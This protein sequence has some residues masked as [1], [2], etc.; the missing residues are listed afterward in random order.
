MNRLAASVLALFA[1]VIPAWIY[2]QSD[3][4][5]QLYCILANVSGS[6]CT[7]LLETNHVEPPPGVVTTPAPTITSPAP[8]SEGLFT[9]AAY[10]QFPSSPASVPSA[11]D[12]SS[13]GGSGGS[14]GGGGGAGQILGQIAQTVGGA[15]V[16][17]FAGQA[18]APVT[19]AIGSA[20]QPI[21]DGISSLFSG[22]GEAASAA[23]NV[24]TNGA[25]NA[26]NVAGLAANAQC[27][28]VIPGPCP[29]GTLMSPEAHGCVPAANKYLC[30]CLATI[31]GVGII[32]G[33]CMAPNFC[34]GNPVASTIA[35]VALS[36][37][38]SSVIGAVA[39]SG[40]GGANGASNPSDAS[41]PVVQAFGGPPVGEGANQLLNGTSYSSPSYASYQ[42]TGNVHSLLF[43][44]GDPNAAS[45]P[46]ATVQTASNDAVD[47][48]LRS[49]TI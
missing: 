25:S 6:A 37:A 35:S 5:S 28:P 48:L 33:Q 15:V 41:N 20:F 13:G 11:S 38:L 2:A 34:L 18:L 9:P 30:P 1:I 27:N 26:G 16:S 23:S 39:G 45:T 17:Q 14:G 21:T 12:Y 24:A 49:L 29:C 40:G 3:S 19:D 10:Q 43:G 8:A 7:A 36:T 32:P 46:S 47:T 42:S 4:A 44:S 22:G 31:A